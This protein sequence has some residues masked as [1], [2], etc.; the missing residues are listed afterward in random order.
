MNI[1]KFGVSV[2]GAENRI[3]TLCFDV[4]NDVF[5]SNGK[6]ALTPISTRDDDCQWL[7]TL[8]ED[9]KH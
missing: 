4:A 2:E 6:C 9:S 8:N 3:K 1:L 7:G 5:V